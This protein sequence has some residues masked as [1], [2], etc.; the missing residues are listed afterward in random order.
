MKNKIAYITYQSFPAD[1]ANSLQTIYNICTMVEKNLDVTLIFPNREE[2]SSENIYDLSSYYKF[3]QK[4]DIQRLKHYLPFGRTKKFKKISFHLSH[5]LWSLYAVS[6]VYKSQKYKAF[7]TRSDWVFLF[8][9][10]LK[11]NVIFECHQKS[12]IRNFCLFF[13]LKMKN[14]KVIF[15]TEDLRLE[16][17]KYVTK[18][19]SSIVLQNGYF[20]HHFENN[21]TKLNKVVFVGEMVRFGDSRNVEF[22]INTFQNDRLKNYELVLIGGPDTYVSYLKNENLK[23]NIQNVKLLNRVDHKTAINEMMTSKVGVLLNKSKNSHSYLYTSPLKYFEYLAAGL[24]VVAVD[25]PSHR[26]LPFSD[27]INFFNENDAESFI[28]AIEDSEK[29]IPISAE[30]FMEYSLENRIQ[31]LIEFARLEGFEPPTL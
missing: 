15:L 8:L 9:S 16:Y 20:S 27:N 21:D 5:F 10:F 23:N 19:D 3:N 4:F 12:K 6:K 22:I 26:S 28:K 17:Q 13:S 14:S 31:K 7:I 29:I 11:K 30:D 18:N 2:L 24:K 1:T 25:F